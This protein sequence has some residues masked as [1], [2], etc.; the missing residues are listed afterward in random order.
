METRQPISAPVSKL[1]TCFIPTIDSSTG[2]LW[3]AKELMVA[4]KCLCFPLR[5]KNYLQT[6]ER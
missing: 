1:G 3:T 2:L 4:Q 5:P 6:L